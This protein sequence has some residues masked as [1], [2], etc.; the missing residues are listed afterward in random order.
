MELKGGAA[1]YEQLLAA[2]YREMMREQRMGGRGGHTRSAKVC[3]RVV[4][5]QV[6][7]DGELQ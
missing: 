6:F 4:K 1:S 3:V 5:F 2:V 7:F